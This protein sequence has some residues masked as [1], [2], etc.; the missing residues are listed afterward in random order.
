VAMGPL[1]QEVIAD[2][3]ADGASCRARI[4]V[5][6]LPVVN[7]DPTLLR[8]VWINL[9]SNA[10]KYS[11]RVESPRIA[12][13]ARRDGPRFTF[14]V[15]DNGAG[16]DMQYAQKLFGVFQ[17]LHRDEEFDGTGVGLAIVQRIVQRHGGDVWAESSLGAGATF[18]FSLPASD[19][20]PER[21][22]PRRASHD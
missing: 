16:F 1:V 14:K 20:E 22:P 10:L 4:D 6:P 11:R 5:G 13:G 18:E 19:A 21:S 15:K 9:L 3:T 7:C 8:Q 2:L 17:R 12:I